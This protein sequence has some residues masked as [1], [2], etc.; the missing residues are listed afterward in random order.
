MTELLHA[1]RI[2]QLARVMYQPA[3]SAR[4]LVPVLQWSVDE[5]TGRPVSRWVLDEASEGGR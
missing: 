4:R 1:D 3:E 5:Q 2:R